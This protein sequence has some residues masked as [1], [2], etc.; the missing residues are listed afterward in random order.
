[1]KKRRGSLPCGFGKPSGRETDLGLPDQFGCRDFIPSNFPFDQLPI[2]IGEPDRPSSSRIFRFPAF[3]VAVF[4][5]VVGQVSC[6]SFDKWT[7]IGHGKEW[8]GN[9]AGA[10]TALSQN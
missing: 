2:R 8:N 10:K 6:L 9:T 3:G 4:S 5:V 1:M 7:K